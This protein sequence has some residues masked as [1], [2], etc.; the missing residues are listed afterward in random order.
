MKLLVI[1][2]YQNDFV[3]GALGFPGAEKLDEKIV[4]L[5][6]NYDDIVFTLD[7]HTE[8]YM[9]TEEGKYLPAPHCIKG[10]KG[11]DVYGKTKEYLNKAKAV[12]EKETFPSLDLGIWLKDHPYDEIDLCGLVSHICVLSN[13]I[14][15]K[16]A[17]PNSH[18]T[19]L[20][21]ATDSYDK[22]LESKTFSVLNGIMIE[23]K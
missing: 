17:L 15:C 6:P 19:V 12:F 5:I 20:K 8:D 4:S 9:K 10:T 3:D 23:V 13:A 11:H 16:A 22:V 14:I 1:V 2:D 21:D 7:T 18:I